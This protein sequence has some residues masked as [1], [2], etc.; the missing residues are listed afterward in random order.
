[1]PKFARKP[2]HS[3]HGRAGAVTSPMEEPNKR[4]PMDPRKLPKQAK[5]ETVIEILGK[6]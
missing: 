5:V 6:G 4:R 2:A 3:I 1:M